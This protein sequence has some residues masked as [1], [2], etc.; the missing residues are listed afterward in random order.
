MSK[1]TICLT[2][3]FALRETNYVHARVSLKLTLA[4]VRHRFY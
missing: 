4:G 1:D 3:N 2:A